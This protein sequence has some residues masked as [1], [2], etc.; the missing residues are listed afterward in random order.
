MR[1]PTVP[2]GRAIRDAHF[3]F[4]E[5]YTP[6]NHGSF[7]ALP[8]AIRGYQ[9][10]MQELTEAKPDTFIRYTIPKLLDE[11][12]AAVAPLLGVSTDEVVFVPNATTAINTVLRN[13]VYEKRDVIMYFSTIYPGEKNTIQ[14]LCETTPLES[15]CIELQYPIQDHKIICSFVAAVQKVRKGG[16]RAKIAIFDTVSTF[17]G[18][19]VPWEALVAQCRKLEILSLID[20]AHGIGHIDLTKLGELQPDFFTTNCYK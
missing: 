9:R 3:N 15:V 6:L 13:L 7:G 2:F 4:D 14:Y 10:E 18:V 16:S 8:T 5:A 12:R 19:R 1:T 20:G 17:P 11:S